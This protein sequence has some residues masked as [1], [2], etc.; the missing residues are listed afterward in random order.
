M[1][2]I[3]IDDQSLDELASRSRGTPRIANRLLKRVRDFSEVISDGKVNLAITNKA[4]NALGIDEMGLEKLDRDILTTIIKGFGGGPV[5]IETI[6]SAIGEER[7]TLEDV[8]E[9]F[10]IQQELLYRTPKG[11]VATRKAYEHLGLEYLFDQDRQGR[12]SIQDLEQ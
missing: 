5:G 8:N 9:P 7:V 2:G 10:L 3:S 4:L 12:F 6:S 1:M 11:R